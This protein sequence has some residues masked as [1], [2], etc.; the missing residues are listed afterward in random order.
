MDAG[1]CVACFLRPG[2]GGLW[3]PLGTSLG[4]TRALGGA[5]VGVGR[6]RR[7]WR[8]SELPVGV[9]PSSPLPTLSYCGGCHG[10]RFWTLSLLPS[11]QGASPRHC[12]HPGGAAMR[13]HQLK[14]AADSSGQAWT[15]CVRESI[16]FSSVQLLSRA[17]LF[18]TPWTVARQAPLS[19]RFPRQEY[20]S[21][22]PF[23]PPGVF[24]TQGSNLPK[25]AGGFCTI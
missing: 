19:M 4:F 3:G 13:K 12:L 11:V 8:G 10:G 5:Q 15:V 24:P 7:Q 25:L 6:D 2:P 20:W 23:P 1:T 16:Q 18:A 14:S 21:G 9:R 22:L 17:Q